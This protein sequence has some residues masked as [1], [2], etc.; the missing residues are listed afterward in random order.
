MAKDW[1]D[2][3]YL[4]R[5]N[6][7]RQMGEMLGV[8]Y[9]DYRHHDGETRDKGY[10]GGGGY[11]NSRDYDDDI[12][13]ALENDYDVREYLRYTGRDLPQTDEERYN[14]YRD[15]KKDHK[16]N[17]GGAFNSRNDLAGVSERAYKES[18][19]LFKSKIL[20]S[21]PEPEDDEQT[22]TAVQPS[23]QEPYTPSETLTDAAEVINQEVYS[24][25]GSSTDE[26]AAAENLKNDY[27]F[28]IKG[29][30]S[31]AGIAT[32][33]PGAVGTPGGFKS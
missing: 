8:S 22:E 15:M 25:F 9:R 14:L 3:D 6:K 2:M 29:G 30:L 18:R 1:D 31:G 4:Q 10:I 19:E 27:S 24:P 23:Q 33:G 26:Q 11:N 5:R 20:D 21:I 13:K 32:R 28:N 7:T 16:Q 17:R 12:K